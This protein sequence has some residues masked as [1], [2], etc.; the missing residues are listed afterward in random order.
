MIAEATKAIQSRWSGTP[1]VG[2]ILGSGLGH[3]AEQI[4]AEACL[5][6]HEIPHFPHCTAL[7]HRGRLVCGTLAGTTVVAME[8]RCHAYE[9]YSLAEI[10]LPV[11]V[12]HALGVEMLIVSNASGGMNP[13]YRKGDI[14]VIED[15][16]NLMF[17]SPL[18]GP[19]DD[20]WGARFPD[21]SH[22]YDAALAARAMEI[23]RVENFAAHRGTYVGV[24]GPNLET[25]AEYRFFRAIGGDVVGMSTVPEVTVA[26]QLGLRVLGLAT[27]TNVCLPDALGTATAHEIVDAAEGAEPKLRKIVQAIVGEYAP[28]SI[29]GTVLPVGS[30]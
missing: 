19:H 20:A 16:I 30:H 3:F 5:P 25:R 26:A 18:I 13:R 2:I 12:M 9:G 28:R 8:G 1:R 10:T 11:R 29:P 4:T 6:Y 27:V 7:A 23:A 17:H 15:H 24:K 22:P 14:V 21:L